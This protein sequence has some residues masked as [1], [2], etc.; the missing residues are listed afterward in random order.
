MRWSPELRRLDWLVARPIAHRGLHSR[1]R[2]IIEN[3]A[4]AFDAAVA[5]NYS[6]ECDLQPSADEEAMVFHDD[7]VDRLMDGRGAVA[8]LP[9]A[10][11]KRLTF[12]EGRDRIQTVGELLDQVAGRVP[13]VIE[14]KSHWDGD[15]RLL[16]RA[17]SVLAPYLG[18]YALMSFDP[19]IVVA[20]RERSPITVR[21]IVADRAT[22]SY[23]EML[24]VSRRIELQRFTHARSSRPHFVSFD[25]A[26]F[27]FAPVNAFRARGGPVI[28]WTIRSRDVAAMAR[29]YSDQITFEGFAA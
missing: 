29:R 2:G 9:A 4:S 16:D 19:D 15:V 5:S 20:L 18:P 17:L 8:D 10:A 27:P 28:S 12:K 6:I 25:W 23:Y 7:T 3:T 22:G 21:G 11:L 24:P 13:L 1:R 14:L 26:G